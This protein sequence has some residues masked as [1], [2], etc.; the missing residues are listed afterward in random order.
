MKSSADRKAAREKKHDDQVDQNEQPL[1]THL[2]AFR[3]CVLR[4]VLVV[5]LLCI[6]YLIF[7]NQIWEFAAEPLVEAL[8]GNDTQEDEGDAQK[9]IAVQPASP[10]LVPIKFALYLSLFTGMPYVLHQLWKFI[11]PGLY[12]REKKFAIPL[13]ASS[14]LLFYAGIVVAYFL[15]L[16]LVFS[17]FVYTTPANVVYQPD[18][19]YYLSF[20]LK[21]FFA[22]GIVFEIPI[23]IFLLVVTGLVQA[24]TLSKARPYIIVGCFVVGM[25]LTPPDVISQ[26]LLALPAWVLFEV[27]LLIARTVRKKKSE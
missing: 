23:V 7:S 2:I 15:V 10:F 9:M 19:N 22:F 16:P 21:I 13:F 11:A 3:G 27:G 4:S 8:M 26:I 12:L 5:G 25:F 6:P 18:I 17:F 24:T 20:M 1:L 14:V